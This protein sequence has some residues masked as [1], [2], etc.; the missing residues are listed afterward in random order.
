MTV[1]LLFLSI[2]RL[3]LPA[4]TGHFAV[5]RASFNWTDQSRR[6][7]WKGSANEPRDLMVYVWYPIDADR[8]EASVSYFPEF[9]A[10]ERN[11]PFLKGIGLRLVTGALGSHCR[12]DAPL[13]ST[14]SRYPLVLFSPGGGNPVHFYAS[15]LEELA[16]Q[17]YVTVAVEP[18]YDGMGQ[19]FPGNVVTANLAELQRP[20]APSRDGEPAAANAYRSFYRGRVEQRAADLR[21]VLD[22]LTALNSGEPGE[23]FRGRLDLDKIGVLGH[24]IGGVAVV[25]AAR[26]DARI[27]AAVNLDGAFDALPFFSDS[28]HPSLRQ[29]L[30]WIKRAIVATRPPLNPSENGT[31]SGDKGTA[32]QPSRT[33]TASPLTGLHPGSYLAILSD[34]RHSDFTDEPFFYPEFRSAAV[35]E[36][37]RRTQAIRDC[38]RE[39]F[40]QAVRGRSSERFNGG[41]SR[42]SRVVIKQFGSE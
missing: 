24:S 18:T 26:C 34:C 35:E 38:C 9:G 23:P 14:D 17:G 16:S 25:E 31:R 30:L 40:D 20:P 33:K 3:V 15:L 32:G 41:P 2:Q 36:R 37:Q 29:P 10:L 8:K 21:F 42:D 28:P 13:A 5:G 6:E 7:I 4:P 19:V 22:R 12:A 1:G 39:F 11:V 27:R